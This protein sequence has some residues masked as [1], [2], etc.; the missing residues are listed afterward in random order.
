MRPCKKPMEAS[1]TMR[2]VFEILAR[3]IGPLAWRGIIRSDDVL[4]LAKIAKR[5]WT[6]HK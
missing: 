1:S 6:A 5:H 3:L 4:E 2:A